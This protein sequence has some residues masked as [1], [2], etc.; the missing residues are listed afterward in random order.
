MGSAHVAGPHAHERSAVRVPGAA[1]GLS[2]CIF[3]RLGLERRLGANLQQTVE[4]WR[5]LYE[6]SCS[7]RIIAIPHPSWR[8]T[9]WLKKNPWFERDLVPVLRQEVERLTR[10]S[11]H[12]VDTGSWTR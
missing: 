12:E 10:A 1:L 11:S 9:G 6:G 2:A 8:N 5:A 7:P 4:N 3:K